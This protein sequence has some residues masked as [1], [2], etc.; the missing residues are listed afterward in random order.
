MSNESIWIAIA[1]V[2]FAAGGAWV[3]LFALKKKVSNHENILNNNRFVRKDICKLIHEQ[4]KTD[5]AL[6][7]A[8]LTWL[9]K[10]IYEQ[11]LN[12]KGDPPPKSKK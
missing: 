3:S 5:M 9:T 8:Q 4:Q 6:M 1:G 10:T 12:Q 2:I 7:Q 11:L